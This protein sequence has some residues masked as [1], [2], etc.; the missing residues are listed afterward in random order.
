MNGDCLLGSG[1]MVTTLVSYLSHSQV[2][3]LQEGSLLHVGGRT[4]R[5]TVEFN[6]EMDRIL[7]SIPERLLV[8]PAAAPADEAVE[9]ATLGNGKPV[10]P[11]GKLSE[12]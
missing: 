11:S 1:L 10:V 8:N 12:G 3:A 5:A 7:N 2:W 6:L 4:N 9:D